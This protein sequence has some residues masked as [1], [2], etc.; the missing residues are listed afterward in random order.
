M[1]WSGVD[2]CDAFISLFGLSFWRHPF[3][4]G[5][6]KLF[7]IWRRNKLICVLSFQ[8]I[9]IFRQTIPL[10]PTIWVVKTTKLL[11]L[12]A[13]TFKHP[14]R[15]AKTSNTHSIR[16]VSRLDVTHALHMQ[17]LFIKN[18]FDAQIHVDILVGLLSL[19]EIWTV[20]FNL[21]KTNDDRTDLCM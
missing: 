1:D 11:V 13:C 2:Y 5:D 6:T 16:L 8:Q 10:K 15:K 17:R 18:T 12:K 9:F 14:T 21:I 20:H 7:Q 19:T 4:A 3:T